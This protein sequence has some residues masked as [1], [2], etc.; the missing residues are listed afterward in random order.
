MNPIFIDSAR[1]SKIYDVDG[2][3]YIDFVGSWGPLILGHAHP[4]V[5]AAV[6]DTAAR[7]TSFGASHPG[8]VELAEMICRAF[9]S[10]DE[11][12]LVN[13]GTEAAMSAVRLARAYTRRDKIIKFTGCYHGHADSFLIQAGSGLLTSGIPTSPGVPASLAA[14]TIVC[15]YNDPEAVGEVFA[16]AGE[17]IAAVIVEPMAGNMGLVLPDIE[18]LHGLREITQ[19]YGSILIFD[20]VIT[21]FRVKYGGLQDLV[22]VKPDLTCLGKIIGGGLPVGAYGGNRKIMN[23][24]APEGPVYQ[25]GT[26][27]GN[28][29]AVAAGIA[30]LKILRSGDWYD[31][32][33][34]L[35]HEL[36]SR[37]RTILEETGMALALNRYGSMFSLFFTEQLVTD[38]ESALTSDTDLY[39]SYFKG[40]LERGIYLPPS[41]FEVCFVS[42]AHSPEDIEKTG[43]ALWEVL[44]ELKPKFTKSGA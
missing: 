17:Q 39:K 26:L 24:L 40:M 31:R 38:Y 44:S 11:V 37:I 23:L 32:L 6:Q 25:A 13:S 29:L 14:D 42:C 41:Q 20:E 12:R 28:P 10:I 22:G 35:T 7:G 27:S 5:V 3:E 16:R 8:E 43:Q 21:G 2:N 18:F 1:G 30:S 34:V 36:E 4:E 15:P 33:D 9:P 19:E